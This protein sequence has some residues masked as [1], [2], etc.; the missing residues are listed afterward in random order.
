M[1]NEFKVEQP[2]FTPTLMQQPW[3]IKA[4]QEA[5]EAEIKAQQEKVV[6]EKPKKS[7]KKK[8][9]EEQSAE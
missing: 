3:E 1:A 8:D 9:S 2:L 6:E 5:R 4:K 7:K